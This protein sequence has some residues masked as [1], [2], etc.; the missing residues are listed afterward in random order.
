MSAPS[1]WFVHADIPAWV[2]GAKVVIIFESTKRKMPFVRILHK[3][4][5][6]WAFFTSL[7]LAARARLRD[8]LLS[9]EGTITR[10]SSWPIHYLWFNISKRTM[11]FILY[12]SYCCLFLDLRNGNSRVMIWQ[13]HREGWVCA[14]IQT[15]SSGWVNGSMCIPPSFCLSK[16]IG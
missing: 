4:Q 5:G 11:Y 3:W 14:G 2:C 16:G 15:P 8:A 1:P 6:R 10:C 7:V 12:Q 9:R 13:G